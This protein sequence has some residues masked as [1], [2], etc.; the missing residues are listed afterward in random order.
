M[1]KFR[2]GNIPVRVHLSF[3]ITTL[4]LQANAMTDFQ[5]I[6]MWLAIAFASILVHELGHALMGKAL[7]LTPEIDIH[8][9][10]GTTSWSGAGRKLSHGKS[11]LVS[12]AGPLAG[13]AVGAVLYAVT[14][15]A[16]FGV[17][18]L[19]NVYAAPDDKRTLLGTALYFGLFIN[20]GWGLF[21]LAPMLP[22]DGGNVL[23]SFLNAVTKNRGERAVR[24]VSIALNIGLGVVGWVVFHDW[25]LALLGALFAVQNFQQL[26]ALGARESDLA[27][28]EPLEKA[29]EALKRE[30]G[31]AVIALA[32]QLLERARTD[33]MRAEAIHLLAYGLLLERRPEEAD[34]IIKRLPPGYTPHASYAELRAQLAS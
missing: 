10:G 32:E 9:M 26:R 19:W 24:I 30:D 6:L 13:L 34:A 8:G 2:L 31:A 14:T 21:N 11:I 20:I 28:K 12:L 16:G 4:I 1:L 7:G 17:A 5:V 25:W 3:L 33:E 27:L 18:G 29:Y 23:R 15:N 22:L